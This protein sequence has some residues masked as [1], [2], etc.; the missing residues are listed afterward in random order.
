MAW[1]S[2]G[3]DQGLPVGKSTGTD[4]DSKGVRSVRAASQ[5][6]SSEGDVVVFLPREMAATV[7]AIIE[8]GAGHRIVADPALQ[9]KISCQDSDPG[10]S[11]SSSL[12]SKMIHC[13]GDVN[14]GGEVLHL[15]AV[16]GN[17]VLKAGD[18]RRELSAA[19]SA[20][21]MESA[22]RPPAFEAPDA[23]RNMHSLSDDPQ[24]YNDA[25][26]FFAEVRR[27]I[28]ES[29]W[30]GVPVDAEEMQKHLEHSVAPVYPDVARKAGVEGDVILRIYVSTEGCTSGIEGPR[31]AAYPRARRNGSR[32]AM[33]ISRIENEWPASSSGN[34]DDRLI[35]PAVKHRDEL[36]PNHNVNPTLSPRATLTPTFATRRKLNIPNPPAFELDPQRR[37]PCYRN[38][39]KH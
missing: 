36:V 26:G 21:W 7:D 12:S 11:L 4:R 14:G 20:N 24:D 5:F 13:A 19:S 22:A 38:P 27:R 33:A 1:L 10:S 29:W 2:N 32:T 15:R 8:Q 37:V 30:G 9:Q 18:P 34:H 6:T 16:S 3:P 39:T 17:I 28:L 23:R 35:P 25:A 31:R